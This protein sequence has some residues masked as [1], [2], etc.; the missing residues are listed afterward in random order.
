M[1]IQV[2][3]GLLANYD[4]DKMLAGELAVTTDS[5]TENQQVFVAFAPGESKRILTEDDSVTNTIRRIWTGVCD[6]HPGTETKIVTLDNPQGFILS[7]GVTIAVYFKNPNRADAPKLNV[8]DTGAVSVKFSTHIAEYDMTEPYNRWGDGM[9]LFTYKDGAWMIA[10][11]EKTDL[12]YTVLALSNKASLASPA[13]TGAPTAPTAPA[14]T[15]TT[16]LATTAFVHAEVASVTKT[17]TVTDKGSGAVEL[18]LA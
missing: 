7:N 14:G 17:L 1:A 12:S 13:F 4:K 11:G 15:N 10:F 6:T 8:N 18:G 2:R 9:K 16:Q 3:R 5:E